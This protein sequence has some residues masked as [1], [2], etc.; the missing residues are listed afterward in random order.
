LL[1]RHPKI[2]ISNF[3]GILH[4]S[5]RVRKNLMFC[6]MY[7]YYHIKP[8]LIRLHWLPIHYRSVF[9]ILL[10]VYKLLNGFCPPYLSCCLEYR[11]SSRSLRSVSNEHLLAPPSNYKTY[12]D[13]S[14]SV[15]APKL[16]N[17]LPYDLRKSSTVS[18]FKK[19][20]KTYLFNFLLIIIR[21][22]I[23][24]RTDISFSSVIHS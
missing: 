19:D 21:L 23:I 11:K 1:G 18:S 7:Y 3:G 8:V 4:H 22:Y 9:K 17:R 6:H 12:G 16:W 10:I 24:I 2:G 15:C 13:R 14:F 5:T 20:L